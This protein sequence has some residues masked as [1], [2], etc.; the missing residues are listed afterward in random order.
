M[1]QASSINSVDA[2]KLTALMQNAQGFDEGDD[3][4]VVTA[5]AGAAYQSHSGSIVEILALG[6][7]AASQA[8]MTK[9]RAKKKDAFAKNK[10]DLED[11]IDGERTALGV[12]R[13]YCGGG[14]KSA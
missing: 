2:A 3:L 6:E 14:D 5:H 9:L 8:A 7:R 11:G 10:Q 12:L 1:G 4:D 13:D